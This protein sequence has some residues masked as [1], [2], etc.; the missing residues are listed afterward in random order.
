MRLTWFGVLDASMS[1]KPL[2]D[3]VPRG[4]KG[5]ARDFE[6]APTPNGPKIGARVASHPVAQSRARMRLPWKNTDATT[7]LRGSESVSC[8]EYL[9]FCS[10]QRA[11]RYIFHS[12]RS[13]F[14]RRACVKVCVLIMKGSHTM[15]GFSLPL[16]NHTANVC[17]IPIIV[18]IIK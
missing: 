10:K 1:T 12:V 13:F 16:N 17:F 11:L 3:G 4:K 18:A 9:D 6:Q 5:C 2:N 7:T 8:G 14:S 15:L